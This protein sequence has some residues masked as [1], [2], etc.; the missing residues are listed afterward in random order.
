MSA[1][2]SSQFLDELFR[3]I[4]PSRIT[5]T[6]SKLRLNSVDSHLA[7][8]GRRN[9]QDDECARVPRLFHL[10]L[11]CLLTL[12]FICCTWF[13]QKD[14]QLADSVF[15]ELGWTTTKVNVVKTP[16]DS[17]NVK[18]ISVKLWHLCITSVQR[19]ICAADR[20]TVRTKCFASVKT[21]P[22][23]D[24]R[25]TSGAAIRPQFSAGFSFLI[26]LRLWCTE[27]FNV[28][29]VTLETDKTC[30]NSSSQTWKLRLLFF[31]NT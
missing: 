27:I 29:C 20:S 30:R 26:A 5:R 10:K 14:F 1:N 18:R 13:P 23:S 8:T 28:K 31:K 22:S 19:T 4:E 6:T 12:K 17:V 25:N 16:W 9:I 2:V 11:L 24:I 7:A 21:F 3:K 15:K